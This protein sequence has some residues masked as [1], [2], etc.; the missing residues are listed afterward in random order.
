MPVAAALAVGIL[1][2]RYLPGPIGLWFTVAI[3]GVVVAAVAMKWPHL[4]LLATGAL[5]VAVLGV[6]A[7]RLQLAYNTIAPDHIATYTGQGKIMA[8]VRG[9]ITS[10][11]QRHRPDVEF[12]YRPDPQLRFL[13]EAEEIKTADGWRKAS[14]LMRVAVKEPQATYSPG[15]RVELIGWMGRYRQKRNPGEFD[16]LAAARRTGGWVWF[17]A[18]CDEAVTVLA[19]AGRENKAAGLLWRF[20]ATL[21]Q[22][23]GESGD[24]QSGRLLNALVLGERHR[25]LGTLN[26]TMKRAGIAH[27]LSISGLHLGVFL[28]F[29]YLLC[30]L[31]GLGPRKAA[32]AVLV[33]LAC[34]LLMA[35]PRPPLLRSA[36]MAAAL[37]LG[38]L[39]GRRHS[40]LNALAVAAI[41]L[42][43]IDPRQLL[44]PGFQLSFAIVAGIILLHKPVRSLLF[45][46]WLGRRGLM[47][48]R[49]ENSVR[50]WLRR[51]AVNWLIAAVTISTT[52]YL[53]AAP[54]A[55]VHFG[56]FSPYAIA[57]S[58]LLFPL[59]VAILIPGYVAMA[60]AGL[61][62]NLAAVVGNWAAAAANALAWI[63]GWLNELPLLAVPL[64]PVGPAWAILYYV[65]LLAVLLGWRKP[66]GRLLALPAV[67]VFVAVTVMTQLPATPDRAAELNIL[68]VGNGQCV[69][70]QTPDGKT[71]LFD[72]GTNGGYD[73]YNRTLEPFMKHQ[74]L[75]ALEAAFVSHANTDHYSALPNLTRQGHLPRTYLC[76]Y[77]RRE[78][79]PYTAAGQMMDVL[80]NCGVDIQYLRAGGKIRLDDRTS[81]EAI[82][83]PPGR[84]DLTSNDASLVLRITCDGKT[85][86]L[87]GD[88]GL[89]AQTALLKHPDKL[90]ADVLILPH[91]G[92]WTKSLPDFVAA[93]GPDVILVSSAKDPKGPSDSKGRARQFYK[94]LRQK[95]RF[96][97]TA[98]KGYIK[99][100]FGDDKLHVTTMLRE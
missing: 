46:R 36:I 54:L 77:F 24:L 73:L 34:Y 84:D 89:A 27:F 51:R 44:Q 81:V 52:A 57:L 62:P 45:G 55:A 29:V 58:V 33:I 5:L 65:A 94:S 68:S 80:K 35:E 69:V 19:P 74:R 42:L 71:F 85:V 31:L 28:G 49:D 59:I 72:A 67:A 88:I 92:G 48:Y 96:Y 10:F 64:R 26:L 90:R 39:S 21:R 78:T 4:R 91:H 56:L 14:G 97:S 87:P 9:R 37:M 60:L 11:P 2:G 30:R 38:V 8:T 79:D 17:K 3:A 6:G 98:R 23:L 18:P 76:D 20:R 95:H 61:A 100:T 25:S 16:S 99:L 41:I 47:V 7:T 15:D 13:L 70:L 50:R 1:L 86:L 63:V 53:V 75:P 66:K 93:V 22:R 40:T 12:G 83:P 32:V 82:W 43:L